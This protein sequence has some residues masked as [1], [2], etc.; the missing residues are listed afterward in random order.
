MV[1]KNTKNGIGTCV[2]MSVCICIY[3]IVMILTSDNDVFEYMI[4][5]MLVIVL[6]IN[7]LC[8]YVS[9]CKTVIISAKGI[10]IE[11]LKYKKTYY[12]EELET[13][14]LVD[15]MSYTNYRETVVFCKKKRKKAV[16]RLG[17]VTDYSIVFHPISYVYLNILPRREK[18]TWNN[19]A[20]FEVDRDT[21]M[22][23][24][25]E[26]SVKLDHE[27]REG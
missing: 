14:V 4:N 13:K 27:K 22:K 24:L 1:I 12:W 10:T 21:L 19:T 8:M 25:D 3:I 23:V 15:N 18:N 9:L 16:P 7:N 11:F 20:F 5:A 17:S 2:T 26:F 6:V